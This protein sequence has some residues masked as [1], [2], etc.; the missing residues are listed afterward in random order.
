M[1]VA[2][3]AVVITIDRAADHLVGIRPD[4]GG[5]IGMGDVDAGVDHGH[6]H[7]P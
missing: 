2:H 1:D 4:V 3:V 7:I 6:H 5:E